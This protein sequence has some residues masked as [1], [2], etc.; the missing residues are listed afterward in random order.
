MVSMDKVVTTFRA[1]RERWYEA[2]KLARGVRGH[3]YYKIPDGIKYR[4][5]APGSCP[6]DKDDH[7]NLFKPHWKTPYRDSPYNIRPVE[8]KYDDMVNTDHFIGAIPQFDAATSDFERKVLLQQQP[9]MDHLKLAEEKVDDAPDSQAMIDEM[10]EEF[11]SNEAMMKDTCDNFA[12]GNW[13]LDE[14]YNQVTFL[15]GGYEKDYSGIG[16]D[17]R[18]RAT[19]EGME[20]IIEEV[21]GKD[22]IEN[23]KFNMIKGNVKKWQILDDDAHDRDEIERI[24][25]SVQAPLPEELERYAEESKKT[26]IGVVNNENTKAWRDKPLATDS[27][28]FDP[29]FLELDREKRQKYFETRYEKP[30]QLE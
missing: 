23:K 17:W 16:N 2:F 9:N 30:K 26:F 20:Y 14:E 7:Q 22:R 4:Y 24:Q 15:A 29:D 8:K 3:A 27:A 12:Q 13:D 5:P 10:W 28:D 21:L 18:S 11:E 19:L 1:T 25:A 6:H